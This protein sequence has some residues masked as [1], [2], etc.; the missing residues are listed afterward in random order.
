MRD[1]IEKILRLTCLALGALLIFQ[2]A[3]AIIRSHPLAKV[4]IPEVPALPIETNEVASVKNANAP[5]KKVETNIHSVAHEKL[6]AT[7]ATTV[8]SMKTE[9]NSVAATNELAG[10]TN[11]AGVLHVSLDSTNA[12]SVPESIASSTK[13]NGTNAT[14]ITASPNAKEMMLTG[15]NSNSVHPTE[16]FAK[17]NAATQAIAKNSPGPR[18]NL[19][20]P[21]RPGMRGGK[22]LPALPFDIQA[23][24]DRIYESELFGQV[25]HPMPAGLM[26]IAGN[27]AFLRSSDGQTGLVKEGDSLG[28]MKLLRIGINR[29]LVEE[30]GEQKELMIFNGYGGE[31]LLSKKETPDETIHK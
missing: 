24:V 4:T 28:E 3:R 18:P 25:M 8:A 19:P 10:S 11:A 6:P 23:R 9:T 21:G 12:L 14:N 31:S 30:K 26:G 5:M 1:R 16:S 15:A 22:S 29:V 17:T 13:G 2:A 20:V 7:N 27:M